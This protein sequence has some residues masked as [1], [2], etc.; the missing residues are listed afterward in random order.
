MAF[1]KGTP[2]LTKTVPLILI[3]AVV[4]PSSFFS[5]ASFNFERTSSKLLPAGIVTFP[6]LLSNVMAF[7]VTTLP[8]P[9]SPTR[10]KA[11]GF[12]VPF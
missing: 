2:E 11:Y 9:P 12:S 7:S 3:S 5:T 10:L 4:I 8:P 6:F 1:V